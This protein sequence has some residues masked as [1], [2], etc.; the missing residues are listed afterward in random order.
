MKNRLVRTLPEKVGIQ[1]Q[2]EQRRDRLRQTVFDF[3][4]DAD[5]DQHHDGK[6]GGRRASH[7]RLAQA[8]QQSDRRA[9]LQPTHK[10]TLRSKP[11]AIEL[12]PHVGGEKARRP[13]GE[14]GN[15]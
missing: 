9:Q 15:G 6:P 12:P 4:S 7:P 1:R 10:G 13:V 8:S 11:V 3:N 2:I 5:G 14:K